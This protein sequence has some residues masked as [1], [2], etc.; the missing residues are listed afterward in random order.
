MSFRA[1][2]GARN[3]GRVSL[4]TQVSGISRRSPA[5]PQVRVAPRNDMNC[6]SPNN[7]KKPGK[8]P[9]FF[10]ATTL[11]YFSPCVILGSEKAASI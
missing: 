8:L 2:A 5:P 1:T 11:N 7:L 9:G 4:Q 3:P 10:Y 6:V